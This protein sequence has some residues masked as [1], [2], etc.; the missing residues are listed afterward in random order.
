MHTLLAPSSWIELPVKPGGTTAD[1]FGEPWVTGMLFLPKTSR[2]S[3]LASEKR[4]AETRFVHVVHVGASV[5]VSAGGL[6]SLAASSCAPAPSLV[7]S[8][9]GPPSP[10]FD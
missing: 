9:P 7:A 4:Y 1:C 5:P 2:P 6:V 3:A 8:S 10:P